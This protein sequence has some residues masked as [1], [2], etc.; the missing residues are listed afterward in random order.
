M[1]QTAFEVKMVHDHR[2]ILQAS[3]CSII[4]DVTF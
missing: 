2:D 1:R 3:A 4:I